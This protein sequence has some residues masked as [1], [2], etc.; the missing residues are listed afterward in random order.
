MQWKIGLF[1]LMLA[2]VSFAGGQKITRLVHAPT[3][4]LLTA[5]EDQSPEVVTLYSAVYDVLSAD[6]HATF[7][8]VARDQKVQA[9]CQEYGVVHL[10]GPMLGC[11][12]PDGVKVWLRTTKPA[13]VE[14]HV[15]LD[16][17][18]SIFG[19]VQS[20]LDGDLVAIVPLT[21]LAP[22]QTYEYKVL[23]DGREISLPE[24]ASFRTAPSEGQTGTMRLGFGTCPHRYGLGN[25]KQ[26]QAIRDR[27]PTA[28]L[29]YGDVGAQDRNNH[30]GLHRAD[31]LLRD[32][33]GAWQHLSASVPVYTLW[34]DHDYFDNDKY[35]IPKGYTD[36]DRRAV[37]KAF[38]QAWNNPG[39][40]FGDEKGGVFYRTRIG[41]ADILM[42]DQRYFRSGKKG[43]LLGEEQMVWLKEQLLDCKGPFIILASST[44]FSDYI[45]GGKDSWGRYDPEGREELFTFIEENN[46]G[47][48]LLISGDRHG[49]RGFRI[50]RESGF[51][52]YE[53]EPASLGGRNGPP[54]IS[55]TAGE[56][57]LFGFDSVYAFGEFEFDTLPK[58]PKVTFRLISED[59]ETLYERKFSRSEL[60]P[61]TK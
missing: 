22:D 20:T 48:V 45:S 10:G 59:G 60:T 46:I 13:K 19:P 39:Y 25:P 54:K 21:G 14:V 11:V 2:S 53:F 35:G 61:G 5:W 42:T 24:G 17:Q 40:G 16:G 57:Q 47:G 55:K 52:F 6:T 27:R 37:R 1:T 56:N 26:S 49:A 28:M 7:A 4:R 23:V 33:W 41:P 18:K 44:M 29:L 43:C 31:Y 51:S 15:L 30:V 12:A 36:E 8:D 38:Q 32:N 34:D 58:D 9:L 50:P 3:S